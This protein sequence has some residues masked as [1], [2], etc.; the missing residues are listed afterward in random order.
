MTSS[1][2]RDSATPFGSP[3]SSRRGGCA[4]RSTSSRSEY[5]I[6][7]GIVEELRER[8]FELGVHGVFHDRSLFSSREEFEPPAPALRDMAERIGADGF[9]SPATHRVNPL[10][11][12][13][14]RSPMTAR[15]RCRTRTSRS[16]GAAARRGRSSSGPV[17]ELPYTMPQ[18]HTMFTLLRQSTIDLWLRQLDLIV[19]ERRAR[20]VRV[21]PRSR[22]TSGTRTRSPVRRVPGR[23]R[24]ATRILEGAAPRGRGVVARARSRSRRSGSGEAGI[25]GS[26]TPAGSVLRAGAAPRPD[27]KTAGCSARPGSPSRYV[28]C[29]RWRRSVHAPC[30]RADRQRGRD[31]PGGA[32]RPQRRHPRRR[33]DRSGRDPSGRRRG[34]QAP[35]PGQALDRQPRAAAAGRDR[36]GRGGARGAVVFAGATLEPGA[37]AGDQSHVRERSRVGRGSVIGRGSSVDNDVLIGERVRVQTNCY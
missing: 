2:T 27:A 34:R 4:R 13:S 6:D 12:A 21:A 17:V 22:A 23:G 10:A 1:R 5:P 7:W 37:I 24:R 16:R 33:P 3:I 20:P 18:D 8:G 14:C 25:A 36:R 11:C 29:P 28:N 30:D 15:C 35:A 32:A 31:R 9:R 19:D 26:T